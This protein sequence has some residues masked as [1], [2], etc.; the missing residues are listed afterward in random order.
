MIVVAIIG[1]LA[2]IAVP[3]F[4]N[5]QIRAKVSRTKSDVRML[6]DQ[7]VIRHMDT[8]LWLIDGNDAGQA[9]H[10]EYEGG[11]HYWG[12][13]AQEAGVDT[14]GALSNTFFN[15]QIYQLLTTPVA[16]INSI[17]TDPF[18]N[19]LFY[20]YEDRGCANA[21]IGT[22][23]LFFASGPDGDTFDWYI[24]RRATPYKP[25]NGLVSNGDIWRSR[26]LRVRP[27]EGDLYRREI[28]QDY[29]G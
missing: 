26:F 21:P 14:Q 2:A 19:G 4:L 9:E 8:G 6:D 23:Y 11:Y 1:I 13:T 25:S 20:G 27:G 15:G 5:A 16:Y 3:N 10:C 7:A 28:F 29:W 12:K 24:G 18:A 17:P 22:H